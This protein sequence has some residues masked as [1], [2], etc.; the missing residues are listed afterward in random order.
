[1]SVSLE[2]KQKSIKFIEALENIMGVLDELKEHIPEGAYLTICNNLKIQYDLK[3][4]ITDVLTTMAKDKVVKEHIA[5]SKRKE[6]QKPVLT[7]AEK[8]Q[9]GWV[10]CNRCDRL[11]L[12]LTGHQERDI[13]NKIKTTKRL[14]ATT[15]KEETSEYHR[16]IALIQYHRS[17]RNGLI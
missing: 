1:M 12:D 15:G 7:D 8:L 3:E 17:K 16:T 6:R 5:R 2:E 13:C 4:Y 10:I 11:V 14:S 9:K